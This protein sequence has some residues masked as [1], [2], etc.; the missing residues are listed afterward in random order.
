[1]GALRLWELTW[2]ET[3]VVAKKD[4]PPDPE[5]PTVVKKDPPPAP[6][7][8]VKKDVPPDPEPPA[9]AK[10]APP[11]D[12]EPAAG[13]RA[14]WPDPPQQA[15]SEKDI[16]N[17]DQFKKLFGK[18]AAADRLKLAEELLKKAQQTADD[19]VG[20]F[21]LLREARDLAALAFN[22]ALAFKAVDEMAK[23]YDVSA[24][25]LKTPV[26]ATASKST[27]PAVIKGVA[28]GA[29]TLAEEALA[30]DTFPAAEALVAQAE[31]AAKKAGSTLLLKKARARAG[32]VA[33][34]RKEYEAAR[35][36]AEVLAKAP[37]DP[38]ANLAAGRYQCLRKAD[39][40]KGLPL[41]A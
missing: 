3:S 18:T 14:R 24:L 31:A 23:D 40:D 29:L 41:L 34:I 20:R 35:A 25:D 26:L 9:V 17:L 1:G 39:W 8:V 2:G 12:P 11:P 28:E 5:P 10:K 21:V 38:A 33:E 19:P 13:K 16:R 27:A 4:G 6:P 7:R 15:R 36:A 30:T 37:D 32:E 22:P